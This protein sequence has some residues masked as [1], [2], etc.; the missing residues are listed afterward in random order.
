[1]LLLVGWVAMVALV[2]IVGTPSL[3][4][5]EFDQDESAP[6]LVQVVSAIT[7]WRALK[8]MEKIISNF[9]MGGETWALGSVREWHREEGRSPRNGTAF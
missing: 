8:R 5:D 6:A 9:F 2:K 7:L 4:L 3:Q 1:M